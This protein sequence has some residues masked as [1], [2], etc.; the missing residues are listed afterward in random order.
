MDID[1]ALSKLKFDESVVGYTLITN[2][3]QLFLS[4]SIPDSVIPQIKGVLKI[5]STSLKMMNVMSE[6]GVVVLGRI[7][8]DWILAVLFAESSLGIALQKTSDVIRLLMQVDLPPPPQPSP[9]EAKEPPSEVPADEVAVEPTPPSIP[10]ETIP[11]ETIRVQHGCVVLRG[12]RFTSAMTMDSQLNQELRKYAMVGM[13]ILL[14][15]DEQRTV[16]KISDALDRPVDDII[17][18][19][20]WCVSR[21]IVDVECPEEQATGARKII[22]VPLFDGDLDKVKKQHRPVLELCDGTRTLNE[23]ADILGIKYFE[24]LQATLP[25]KGKSLKFVK[26]DKILKK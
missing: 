23:V 20:R 13:D 25:Y 8:P 18:V 26:T 16:Y 21:R 17:N 11:L 5:H 15:V 3:G 1:R 9:S 14:M 24:A 6:H 12:P 4:F 2:D 7:N 22:E 10:D 19:V